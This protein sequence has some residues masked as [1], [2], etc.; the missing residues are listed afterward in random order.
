MDLQ[1]NLEPMV[2]YILLT[3]SQSEKKKKKIRPDYKV[4]IPMMKLWGE[5]RQNRLLI[6]ILGISCLMLVVELC[7]RRRCV[8]HIHTYAPFHAKIQHWVFKQQGSTD[9]DKVFSSLSLL[10]LYFHRQLWYVVIIG[11]FETWKFTVIHKL[12]H[13]IF[14]FCDECCRRY[15]VSF[16]GLLY[17]VLFYAHATTELCYQV[18]L[19]DWSIKT[20][21]YVDSLRL[22]QVHLC[23][24]L[25][26]RPFTICTITTSSGWGYGKALAWRG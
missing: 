4:M 22:S 5:T 15:S 3:E 18:C 14:T 24:G 26:W 23:D 19:C 6:E 16:L 1:S 17:I 20:C 11:K 21:D 2:L 7:P 13:I 25:Y 8:K 9:G 12:T 10:A